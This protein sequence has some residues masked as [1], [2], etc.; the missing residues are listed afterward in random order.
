MK[1]EDLK[2]LGLADD[3][4]DTIMGLHGKTVEKHKGDLASLTTERDALKTQL[5]EAGKQ[6]EGFKSLDIEGVK[7]QADEWK[8][9]AEQAAKDADAKIWQ[10]KFDTA[11]EKALTGAKAHNPKVAKSL[12]DIELLKK[13]YD[14][15]S[16][17]IIGFDEHLKPV[18][19]KEAWAFA[20]DDKTPTII[21]GATPP[22]QPASA[23]LAAFEK[24]AGIQK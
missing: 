18:K 14:E 15:K 2:A 10:S 1:R 8:Q 4:I 17:T 16:D 11:I 9:K 19:E 6:I 3:V 22:A 12:L 23:F 20:S 5:T 7:R 13:A 24:G 21:K